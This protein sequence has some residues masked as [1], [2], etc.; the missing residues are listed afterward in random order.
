MNTESDPLL[1]LPSL[2]SL[3]R[4]VQG[5][6]DTESDL[7]TVCKALETLGQLSVRTGDSSDLA[8]IEAAL[9]SLESG[10]TATPKEEHDK[11]FREYDAYFHVVRLSERP[12]RTLTQGLLTSY[13]GFL[14]QVTAEHSLSP[15]ERGILT[16]AIQNLAA[17]LRESIQRKGDQP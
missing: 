3:E 13:E 4:I 14:R 5:E 17:D 15:T 10:T 2:E 7:G 6:M 11:G 16:S 1:Y 9:S 12:V 8:V